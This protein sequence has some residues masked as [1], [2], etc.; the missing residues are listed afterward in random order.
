MDD[1]PTDTAAD[2]PARDA[3]LARALRF[4]LTTAADVHAHVCPGVSLNAVRKALAKLVEAGWLAAHP[5]PA[6]DKYYVPGKAAVL[7]LGLD[8]RKSGA[9]GPQALPTRLGILLYCSRHPVTKPT[10]DEFKRQFTDLC[11]PGLPATN[12]VIEPGERF[13]VGWLHVDHGAEPPKVVAKL[14][15]VIAD[16]RALPAFRAAMLAGEFFVAVLVPTDGRGDHLRRAYARH[17]LRL[18][19]VTFV[20]VPEL[21]PLL[22]TEG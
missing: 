10:A 7:E 14:R 3:V 12:Y 15:G 17:A 4:G 20:T 16:R 13:R 2:T 1:T 11:R 9:F 6:R 22:V 18:I 5:L 21:L 8:P 19:E